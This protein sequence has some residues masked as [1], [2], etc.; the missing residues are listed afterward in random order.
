MASECIMEGTQSLN[1]KT[2]VQFRITSSCLPNLFGPQL[3][4]C[5]I[6]ENNHTISLKAL[7]KI[8]FNTRCVCIFT[9]QILGVII[10]EYILLKPNTSADSK[11]SE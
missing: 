4:L 6:R 7:M 10:H 9:L 3:P 5:K 11:Y 8:S 1:Q 2:L